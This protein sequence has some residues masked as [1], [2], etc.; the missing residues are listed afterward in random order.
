MSDT[1]HETTVVDTKS[2]A[3]PLAA[4]IITIL[5]LAFAFWAFTQLNDGD[6]SVLPDEVN[7]TV[8]ENS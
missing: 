6:S 5:V 7:I 3:G 8:D 2:D 1:K 4:V